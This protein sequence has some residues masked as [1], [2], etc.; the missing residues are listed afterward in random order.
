PHRDF[1]PSRDT[2][3]LTRRREASNHD[4]SVMN[5][6]SIALRFGL[7]ARLPRPCACGRTRVASAGVRTAKGVGRRHRMH[8]AI[9]EREIMACHI[10]LMTIL[11]FPSDQ[12]YFSILSIASR[13]SSNHSLSSP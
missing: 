4:Y 5:M 3:D 12:E 1:A 2:L 13:I 8:L 10:L 9:L 7:G 11:L 6:K